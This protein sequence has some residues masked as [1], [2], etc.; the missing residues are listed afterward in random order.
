[1]NNYSLNNNHPLIPNAN[2]YFFD[3]KYVSIHSE[4]RD[5]LKYPNSA[6][7]EIQ[8]PEDLLNIV[9][10]RLSTWSFPSNYNVFSVK[11]TNVVMFFKF[12]RLYNPGE[13]PIGD[14]L[15]EAI[16]AGL[17][18][19]QS[20][21]YRVIIET[22]FYNPLQMATELT[23]KL[24]EAVTNYLIDYFTNTP[25][26]NYALGLFEGYDRFKVVYNQVGQK[27][28]FANNA[29]Q[30]EFDNQYLLLAS[31][32]DPE[33]KCGKRALTTFE[34]WGLPFNL[35]FT[36]DNAV[37]SLAEP[38][39]TP[40][41][42]LITDVNIARNP[43]GNG[44]VPRFY[45]GDVNIGDDGYWI[46]PTL[47]EASV[48]YLQCPQ[49]INFM[50][51]AYLYMEIAGLNCMD[52]TEPF[53]VSEF[54]LHTNQTNGIANSAFAKI[55]IPVTPINQ[56]FDREMMPFKWFNPPA[57]RLRRLK[58]KFRY[59]NGQLVDFSSFDYSFTLEFSLLIPQSDRSYSIKGSGNLL[60]T[61]AMIRDPPPRQER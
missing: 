49:K 61:Q 48:Y 31:S 36:R 44:Y 18:N 25:E 52:E 26:Y 40:L 58:I 45:Y 34:N 50:G 6:E 23:N 46:L 8:L 60:Q 1:M 11:N 14:P 54:T 19:N 41:G 30:F 24:N 32:I 35:G 42:E 3:K 43:Y 27:L 47:P 55:S 39:S 7:F 22:G 2:Q 16:F 5:V 51:P 56:Y 4:D 29:D 37:S 10:V 21:V 9:S 38:V 15:L 57:E 59:H 12:I 53:N 13:I 20:N 28:W 33:L 17:Y